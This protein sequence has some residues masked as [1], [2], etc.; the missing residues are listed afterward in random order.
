[1][2]AKTVTAVFCASLIGQGVVGSAVADRAFADPSADAVGTEI[3]AR[4]HAASSDGAVAIVSPSAS[5]SAR[6]RRTTTALAKSLPGGSG[7][8][9]IAPW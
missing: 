5:S 1:M 7:A 2:L 3:P 8:T 6:K 4:A 9:S